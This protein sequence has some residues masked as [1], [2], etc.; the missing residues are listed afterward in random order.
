[1]KAF[2]LD[3]AL[4]ILITSTVCGQT[5]EPLEK[6]YQKYKHFVSTSAFMLY[7]VFPTDDPPRFYQVNY[8]HRLTE[9]DAVI[10]EAITWQYFAP[11][12]IPYGPSYTDKDEFFPGKVRAYGV[13]LA[14]QRFLWKGLYTTLHATPLLQKYLSEEE[15]TIQKGF[16]LFVTARIGYH[17]E[18]FR[19]RIFIEPS[20]AFTSWPVNTNMPESFRVMERKWPSYFLFE[21]GL[22]AGFQF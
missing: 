12:G 2:V 3:F 9:K 11:L 8:G 21:P 4:S 1:M 16:Q 15:E 6:G 13:G 22:H 19:N 17:L 20:V 10:V 7:N 18:V 5:P 14:Y